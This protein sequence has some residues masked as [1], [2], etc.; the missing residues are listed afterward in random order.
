MDER[1]GIVN[2][3]PRFS[4]VLLAVFAALALTLA[5]VGI[6]GVTAHAVSRRTRE[7]GI[8]IALG[9][10]PAAVSGL[11]VRQGLR[12]ILW[13]ALVGI[14]GALALT[15]VLQSQLFGISAT[16]PITFVATSAVLIAVGTAACYVP[17]RRAARVDPLRT[18]RTE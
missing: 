13:G 7:I 2:E 10:G 17:A 3:R 9:A 18:L 11:F 12:L 14:G 15:R 16:D 5:S 8:R 1:F 6:F 4:A